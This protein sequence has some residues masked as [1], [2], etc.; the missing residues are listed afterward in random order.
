MYVVIH[1]V[2]GVWLW[3]ELSKPGHFQFIQVRQKSSALILC[4]NLLFL[5]ENKQTTLVVCIL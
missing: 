3:Q 2:E 4:H 1:V 5:T